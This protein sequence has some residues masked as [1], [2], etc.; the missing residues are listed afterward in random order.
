MAQVKLDNS[1]NET[2]KKLFTKEYL[3]KM[4]EY[5]NEGV[6]LY[7]L[8]TPDIPILDKDVN[9]E[10]LLDVLLFNDCMDLKTFYHSF[11][12]FE[13]AGEPLKR[14]IKDIVDVI[15]NLVNGCYRT[16]ARTMFAL[17]ESESKN[18]SCALE[19]F[20]EKEHTYKRGKQRSEIIE[21]LTK[22]MDMPNAQ[23][24]WEMINNYYEKLVTGKDA[25]IDRNKLIHGDYSD[26]SI[27]INAHDVA[28][29]LLLYLSFRM[30]GDYIQN[31]IKL[32]TESLSY[33]FTSVARELKDKN[34]D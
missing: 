16:A 24:E 10:L 12:S 15:N 21:E 23:K 30:H 5:A 18:I 19:D 31:H 14:K 7:F 17:L 34:N 13:G 32:Y 9:P 22:Y 27:D 4:E 26:S 28:K 2:K 8:E 20:F 6:L 1:I 11:V 3:N 33:V 25:F 29:L